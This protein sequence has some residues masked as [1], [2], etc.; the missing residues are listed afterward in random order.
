VGLEVDKRNPNVLDPSD[1]F[2]RDPIVSLR[3]G[4]NSRQDRVVVEIPVC[5]E[6][7]HS[8]VFEEVSV[9]APLALD[10]LLKLV[11]A[12]GFFRFAREAATE[13]DKWTDYHFFRFEP[14]M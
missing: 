8:K 12:E 6:R 9:L 3:I 14:M 7:A 1:E 11:R 2:W 4:A 5:I 13:S 10:W